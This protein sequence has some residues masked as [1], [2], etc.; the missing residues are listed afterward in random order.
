MDVAPAS[1]AS[2]PLFTPLTGFQSITSPEITLETK[3]VRECNFH[4]TRKFVKKGSVSQITL[5]R[6]ATF[7]DSDFY[8]WILA[9]AHGTTEIKFLG[10]FS[11]PGIGSQFNI[12]GPTYRRT[13]VLVQ[14]FAHLGAGSDAATFG[15]LTGLGGG[16][17]AKAA[18]ND[19]LGALAAVR[20]GGGL[21]GALAAS[22]LPQGGVHARIPAR[23]WYLWGCVP[24]R[25]KASSDFEGESADVSIMELDM[26]VDMIEEISLSSSVPGA[27]SA[28]AIAGGL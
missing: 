17:I 24:T 15:A 19:D 5:T 6:G 25:Y 27:G 23:A 21:A 3:E 26:Q 22:V 14:F 2:L 18:A 16:V 20:A 4:F 1:W 12:G 13:M 11:I 7:Y 8:N 10:S 9:A 28:V